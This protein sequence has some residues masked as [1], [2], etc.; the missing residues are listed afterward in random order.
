MRIAYFINSMEGG[1]A[2][3][4]LPRIVSTL[5]KAGAEVGVFA[6][7]RRNGLAIERLREGGI[8][9]VVRGGSDGDHPA[10]LRWMENRAK[11][12]K[13]DVVWT[14][15][16]RATLLGQIAGRRLGLPVVSWQHNAFLKPWNERLLRWRARA[17]DIWIA[18]SAQVAVLTRQRLNVPDE[19][20][21]TW[22]IF[23]ADPAAPQAQPWLAGETLRIGSLGRLHPAKGYDLL[24]EA[25]RILR[26]SCR[27][28]EIP[29]EISIGGEGPDEGELKRKAREAGVDN[30]EF[31][32]FVSDPAQFLAR[33]HLYLQPSR[34]EG[35]CIAAH[36][37]MQAGLPVLAAQTG[38][39]PHT[40][41]SDEIGRTFPVGDVE[42]LADVLESLLDRP[43]SLSGMGS[44]ARGRV[45]EKFSERKFDAIGA[46]IVERLEPL[47]TKD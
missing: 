20:L 9:P 13:A 24:I 18:D 26:R 30:V 4:P 8:E 23:A 16:T 39:M 44:K 43:H 17:S 40:I 11:D 14:S 15:L 37:A 45:L 31:V 25:L 46:E 32:G 12:W 34:R 36:E 38:E 19:R 33:Q 1:G 10:A 7:S 42:A 47:M 3:S 28:P 2:Q 35:F 29:F 41:D 21:I 27:L 6:L 22:P 5:R